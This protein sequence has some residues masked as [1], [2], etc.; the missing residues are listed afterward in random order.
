MRDLYL[1][2]K[3]G[4]QRTREAFEIGNRGGEDASELCLPFALG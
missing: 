2:W 4:E 1:N 3:M